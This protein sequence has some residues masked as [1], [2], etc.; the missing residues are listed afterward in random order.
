MAAKPKPTDVTG[1]Q[2]EKLIKE[3]AEA[4]AKR[5]EEMSIATAV[6]N[7]RM[8]KETIDLSKVSDRPTVIDEEIES[9]GVDLADNTVVVRVAEDLDMMTVGAGKHYSFKAGVK[10]KV[11]KN[12]AQQLQ[13]KG[14]LYDRL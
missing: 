3:N 1:R 7:I 11:P 13:E 4:L 6:D 9:V 8:E 2:R 14:Y 12:V 10:Y 5:A